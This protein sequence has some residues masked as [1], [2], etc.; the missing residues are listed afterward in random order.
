MDDAARIKFLEER[1]AY[2][3][4]ELSISSNALEMA[5]TFS[6]FGMSLN[7]LDEPDV[8]LRETAA[9]LRNIVDFKAVA[10]YLARENDFDFAKAYCDRDDY[11]HFIAS[12]V[13]VLIE[14]LTF[15]WAL[16]RN[17]PVIVSAKGDEKERILM[18]ALATGSRTRGMFV[19][20][21]EKNES[22]IFDIELSLLTLIMISGAH[23]LE[24]FELYSRIREMNRNLERKVEE[25]TRE[26]RQTNIQLLQEID[27]RSRIERELIKAKDQAEAANRA[28]GQF[29]GNMSHEIRTP[30]NGILGLT[31]LTLET[32]LNE[33]QRNNLKM[34]RDSGKNLL[35]ILQD[36]L[37]LSKIEAGKFE[38]VEEYF[39]VAPVIMS[40]VDLFRIEAKTKN[41]EL[42]VD[43]AEDLPSRLVGDPIRLRQVVCNLTGNALKFTDSGRIEV[44][45]GHLKGPHPD[46]TMRNRFDEGVVVSVSDTGCGI[47]PEKLEKIFEMFNQVDGSLTRKYQGTGLGLT[48]SRQLVEMMGGNIWVESSVGR[49]STFR[50]SV[51]FKNPESR[52]TETKEPQSES[53]GPDRPLRVLV[54]DDDAVNIAFASQ[55]LEAKGHK[56]TAVT[57]GRAAVKALADIRFDAVLMDIQMPDLDGIEATKHIRN[58]GP[59]ILDP[60][61]P[62]IAVTAHALKGDRETFLHAGMNG[63]ISKPIEMDELFE[64]LGRTCSRP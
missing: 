26:L 36:V 14:D 5:A 32:P 54:A 22:E 51:W 59:D 44:K 33:E 46:E 56:V 45:V 4:E 50:F 37:D 25:R 21:L 23:A 9:K 18:H 24:S 27:E 12:E 35:L 3:K 20:I 63:Y 49:G 6:N 2:L 43:A 40:A 42:E 62:I 61:V 7:K 16:A 52:L 30:L 39:Q 53:K 64:I 11:S 48:I 8:I 55:A 19:G 34:I 38:L 28:K 41:L 60:E 10:F 17:K 58:G 31:E 57:T 47:P 1:L 13:E 29:L 15:A